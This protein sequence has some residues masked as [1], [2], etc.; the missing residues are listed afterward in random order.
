MRKTPEAPS[1]QRERLNATSEGRALLALIDQFPTKMALAEALG[2]SPEYVSRCVAQ[3]KI[4]KSGAM[5]ADARGF[6]AKEVLRPD[7]KDWD[8]TARGPMI[9]GNPDRTKPVHAILRE[10]SAHFG[11]VKKF[12]QVFGITPARFHDWNSSAKIPPSGLLKMVAMRK[13]PSGIR[14]KIAALVDDEYGPR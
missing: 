4:S 10:M 9:G 13:L 2:T 6:M 12:C 14:K 7:V 5:A 3:G 11:S 1:E 8:A